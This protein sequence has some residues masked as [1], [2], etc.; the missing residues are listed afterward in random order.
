MAKDLA[1]QFSLTGLGKD[2][3]RLKNSFKDHAVSNITIGE[4]SLFNNYL[5]SVC[6][7]IPI[8]NVANFCWSLGRFPTVGAGPTRAEAEPPVNSLSN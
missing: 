1:T 3:Q 8:E 4:L 6:G 7:G 2:R 5:I